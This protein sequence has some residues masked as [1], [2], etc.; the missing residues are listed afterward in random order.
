M[1]TRSNQAGRHLTRQGAL[2][3]GVRTNIPRMS[4]YAAVERCSRSYHRRADYI[5]SIPLPLPEPAVEE[6]SH[7][8][9][10][11]P[12]WNFIA[13]WLVMFLSSAGASAV[14]HCQEWDARLGK[15]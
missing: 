13:I 6:V 7:G 9:E 15:L 2:K 3:S 11:I 8:D 5:A 10:D 12:A 14:D 4:C 1:Q